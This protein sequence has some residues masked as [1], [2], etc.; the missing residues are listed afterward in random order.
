M[1]QRNRCLDIAKGICI[2]CMIIVHIFGWWD[3]A[4]PTFNMF[5]GTFF[6]VFFFV[7]SGMCFHVKTKKEY[8]GRRIKR[9]LVPYI[10]WCMVYSVY[11]WKTGCFGGMGKADKI[12]TVIV[13]TI[14]ALP[15]EFA[16]VDI[17][18][19]PT[20]GV[21]PAW[22]VCCIFVTNILYLMIYKWTPKRKLSLCF[23]GVCV[24]VISQHYVLL[25]FNLQDAVIGC[26]FMAL[27]E[28]TKGLFERWSNFHKKENIWKTLTIDIGM[29]FIYILVV[30]LPYQWM[31]LGG[32]IYHILSLPSTLIGFSIL[33]AIAALIERTQVL[34]EIFEE[35]GRSSMF[36]LIMHS[37]D[38]LMIRD[39][40]MRD[41][42]FF[43]VTLMGYLFVVYLVHRCRHCSEKVR[44][45]LMPKSAI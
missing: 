29:M 20:F 15:V 24:A 45:M 4:Y 23:I 9:L 34:D 8:I 37:A 3:N 11:R 33:I 18:H 19:V 27:G 6:L 44:N 26:F 36:V 17:F 31:N 39:W 14:T 16:N 12:L 10:L 1:Q 40:W 30:R 35:Y 25:P 42:Y 21:G 43:A 13:S 5:T 41:W 7:A 28:S 38:I 2:V 22:F 32:N